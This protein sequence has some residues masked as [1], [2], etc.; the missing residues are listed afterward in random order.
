[1]YDIVVV[2][3]LRWLDLLWHWHCR[4]RKA[5]A[6]SC[7]SYLEGSNFLTAAVSTPSNC[8]GHSLLFLSGPE[9][10][11]HCLPCILVPLACI[12]VGINP[13]IIVTIA[14]LIIAI[15]LLILVLICLR[16]IL[17]WWWCWCQILC[18]CD[19]LPF[20]FRENTCFTNVDL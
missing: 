7:W 4:G 2:M 3:L 19:Y 6:T 1:M 15:P 18:W 16:C 5:I 17:W 13:H 11:L 8:S 9:A 10:H 14:L 20:L 12:L